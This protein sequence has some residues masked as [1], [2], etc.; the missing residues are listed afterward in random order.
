MHVGKD[1]RA[2][3]DP[4][5]WPCIFLKKKKRKRKLEPVKVPKL[6]RMKN[7]WK[8]RLPK[9]KF[10][11][12]LSEREAPLEISGCRGRATNQ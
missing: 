3:V 5:S 12:I 10:G 11:D 1:K 9:A 7:N 6:I 2:K 8:N 4:K